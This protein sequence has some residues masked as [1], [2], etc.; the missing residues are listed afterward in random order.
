MYCKYFLTAWVNYRRTQYVS[1]YFIL[2]DYLKPVKQ[3]IIII[4][5]TCIGFKVQRYLLVLT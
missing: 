4:Q 2:S 3:I 5:L 1:I